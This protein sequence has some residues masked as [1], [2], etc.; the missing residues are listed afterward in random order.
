MSSAGALG[1]AVAIVLPPLVLM[2]LWLWVRGSDPHGGGLL[3]LV[4]YSS[5]F[6]S[7]LGLLIL[8]LVHGGGDR[9]ASEPE[10]P[11]VDGED[12]RG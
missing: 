4:A 3:G 9:P 10:P 8:A 2:P 11:A 1:C 12:R 7:V 6:L 5:I